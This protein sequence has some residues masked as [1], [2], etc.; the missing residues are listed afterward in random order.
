MPATSAAPFEQDCGT[1]G[2]RVLVTMV[3]PSPQPAL[4]VVTTVGEVSTI[5]VAGDATS[6]V[7]V[8]AR[9]G[10]RVTL[11]LLDERR[12]VDVAPCASTS[13]ESATDTVVATSG[14]GVPPPP[15]GSS[16]LMTALAAGALAL[17]SIVGLRRLR[18]REVVAEASAVDSEPRV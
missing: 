14:P 3:N 5:P 15:V 6:V 16:E 13:G 9:A 11:T 17:L 4:A 7:S 8:P 12:T 1:D 18:S 10:E 2:P